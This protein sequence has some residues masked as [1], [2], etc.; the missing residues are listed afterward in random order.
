MKS[1]FP[2]FKERANNLAVDLF[3]TIREQV[4][5]MSSNWKG[6]ASLARRSYYLFDE[7]HTAVPSTG[8]SNSEAV[9]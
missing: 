5:E 4:V 3:C 2:A 7:T 6:S 8:Y 1:A 9:R